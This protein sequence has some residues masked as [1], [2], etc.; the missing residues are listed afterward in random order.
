[1]LCRF[2]VF[3]SIIALYGLTIYVVDV[4]WSLLLVFIDFGLS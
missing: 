2:V 1:M 3:C 4:F